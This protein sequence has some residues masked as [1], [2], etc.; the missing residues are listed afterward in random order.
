MFIAS[1]GVCVV[2][3]LLSL[4]FDPLF[5]LGSDDV[6][7][8]LQRSMTTRSGYSVPNYRLIFQ[9]YNALS[10]GK[11]SRSDFQRIFATNQLNFTNSELSKVM[12]RFDVNK[13]GVVDYA[14]FLRYVTGICD[15]S[16]RI[17]GRVSDAA[18]EIRS[19]AIEKQNKKL[20]KDGNIDS[21]S[22]WKC[23]KLKRGLVE[24]ASLDHVLRQRNVR[25]DSDKLQLL[26]VLMAPATNGDVN[27]A[28]FHA[29]V[30]HYPKKM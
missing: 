11:L 12:Q 17:A 13:D 30:N 21:T 18:E 28:S 23:F 7:N 22:A 29:F 14:D 20:A 10:D 15:A 9:S 16:S 8:T 4:H 5:C 19:W 2:F 1:V 27:Q 25:L 24:T 26:K 3:L 6:V